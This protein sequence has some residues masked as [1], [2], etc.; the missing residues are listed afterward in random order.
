MC[1]R[2]IAGAGSVDK[3][4]R[5][6]KAAVANIDNEEYNVHHSLASDPNTRP[7]VLRHLVDLYT[8][9]RPG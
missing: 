7:D 4:K 8:D 9:G 1:K 3:M 2:K 5:Y 6:V